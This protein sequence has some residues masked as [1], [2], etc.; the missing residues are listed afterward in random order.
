MRSAIALLSTVFALSLFGCGNDNDEGGVGPNGATSVKLT[1]SSEA[2]MTSA[3]DT[4][5][6]TAVVK[7]ADEQ[8]IPSPALRWTSNAPAVATVAGTGETA[9]ITAVGDGVATISAA[10]GAVKGTVVVTVRRTLVSVKLESPVPV[11]TLGSS[12]QLVATALDAR[13]NEIAGST[14]FTYTS[15]NPN[16]LM[17]S[18]S[19][20][21]TALFGFSETPMATITAT[22][23]RDGVTASASAS[24]TT[25]VPQ[26]FDYAAL[27]LSE[28]QKPAPVPTLGGGVG[29]KALGSEPSDCEAHLG[30]MA[31]GSVSSP[32]SSVIGFQSGVSQSTVDSVRRKAAEF[33]A[34]GNGH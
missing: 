22:L 5:S 23:T 20:L 17:V 29:G 16:L 30:S 33:E 25:A 6:V 32:R 18:P 3:G 26:T 8:V 15:S 28:Y 13:E 14:G 19:G 34:S 24:I 10:T 12:V 11:L 4:R 1:I 2:V 21:V 7:S 31:S 27:M 9:T